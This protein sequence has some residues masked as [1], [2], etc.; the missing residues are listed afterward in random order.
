[1]NTKLFSVSQEQIKKIAINAVIVMVLAGLAYIAGV[2]PSIVS[3]PLVLTM[4]VAAI[5]YL[6]EYLTDE[7]GKLGGK[8]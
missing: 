7:Q 1:M 6:Q 2:L 8:I 3:N 5:N 4:L